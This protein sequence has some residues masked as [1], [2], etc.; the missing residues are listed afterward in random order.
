MKSKQKVDFSIAVLLII[1]GIALVI[2]PLFDVSNVKVIFMGVMVLYSVLNLIQY[3]LTFKSHDY[4][5]LLTAIVSVFV[6]ILTNYFYNTNP[7]TISI[8]LISWITLMA[9]VKLVKA[10]YYND[11]RDRMWKLKILS[12]VLFILVGLVSAISFNYNDDTKII[13]LGYFF[14]NHGM[15]ELIDPMVKYLITGKKGEKWY[16]KNN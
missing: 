8:I 3:G 15:L 6:A 7:V 11:R 4:E 16:G 1:M 13:V 9:I 5:G 12:L 2:F 10:D 14:L